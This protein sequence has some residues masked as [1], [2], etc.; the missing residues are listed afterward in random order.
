MSAIKNISIIGPGKVG[1]AL[2]KLLNQSGLYHLSLAGRNQEKTQ[3]AANFISKDIEVRDISS[4]GQNA[5]LTFLTVSD[6]AIEPLCNVL[7]E[8]HSISADSILVHCSG[9]LPSSILNTAQTQRGCRIASLHPLQT[10]PDTESAVRNLPG[11]YCFYEGS[12][13][14]LTI[15]ESLIKSIQ[16]Q[17]VLI[18]PEA[19]ILYHTAAVMACNYLTALMDAAL[20]TGQQAG[21]D[22]DVLWQ[23][24]S[25]L[26]LATLDN[27]NKTNPAT[28]LTGPIAR[29]DI[30]TVGR[31]IT[32]LSQL[33]QD[34]SHL[35]AIYSALGQQTVDLAQRKGTLTPEKAKLLEKIINS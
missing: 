13:E 2:T 6:D 30:K 25:P 9:A 27:I 22:A 26:V 10:F 8:T 31:H 12:E 7:V 18:T 16:L 29:G 1:T 33:Q 28:A 34:N 20:E 4:A 14:V 23:G 15:L 24:L 32:Q 19:K 3:V 5:D 35:L 11:T 17:P 21:I